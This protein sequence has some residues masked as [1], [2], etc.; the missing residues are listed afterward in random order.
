MQQ[1][2]LFGARIW[3]DTTGVPSRDLLCASH[4]QM[5]QFQLYRPSINIDN[6]ITHRDLRQRTALHLPDPTVVAVAAIVPRKLERYDVSRIWRIDFLRDD[7]PI[8]Q[9][10]TILFGY[11]SY[12][13]T[14]RV[15]EPKVLGRGNSSW[16]MTNRIESSRSARICI[17][18]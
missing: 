17:H 4:H 10:Y 1:R 6:T 12:C 11:S 9:A 2:H 5:Y 7:V 3:I 13:R 16:K 8:V 18:R 15:T 14:R